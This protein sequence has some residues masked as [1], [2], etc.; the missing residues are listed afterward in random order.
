MGQFPMNSQFCQQPQNEYSPHFI[1]E[2]C[3]KG[4]C[5]QY[6]Q[7]GQKKNPAHIFGNQ[8]LLIK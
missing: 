5:Y 4:L 3:R 6:K 2:R 8:L 7:S 1:N